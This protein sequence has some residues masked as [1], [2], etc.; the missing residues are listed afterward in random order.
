[1][2]DPIMVGG[3]RVLAQGL[4]S[5]TSD[6]VIFANS[7]IFGMSPAG[8]VTPSGGSEAGTA[9]RTFYGDMGALLSKVVGTVR[10]KW[11]DLGETP[12]RTPTTLTD[13]GT[14]S[15]GSSL[16]SEVAMCLSYYNGTVPRPKKRGRIF[17]GP[18]KE[19]VVDTA[20]AIPRISAAARTTVLDALDT[21]VSSLTLTEWGLLSQVDEVIWPITAGY[22][23]DAFDIQRRR[24]EDPVTRTT[25]TV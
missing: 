14:A 11:Y 16:P 4:A 6:E 9:V 12:P 18:L 10:V 24:G 13:L 1:M 2:A 23:D 20:A 22:I 8:A 5:S 25:F 7:W 17:L 19:S 3:I 21:M 15:S